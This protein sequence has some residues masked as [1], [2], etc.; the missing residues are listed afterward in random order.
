MAAFTKAAGPKVE[1]IADDFICTTP[2]RITEAS[3]MGA[4]NT[5]LIKP[6]QV[7][8]HGKME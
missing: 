5:A 7:G 1:V 4:C 3:D 2:A 6:N 8:T